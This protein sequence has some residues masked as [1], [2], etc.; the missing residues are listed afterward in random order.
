MN[1]HGSRMEF[2]SRIDSLCS[3]SNGESTTTSGPGE[4]CNVR[5]VGRGRPKAHYGRRGTLYRVGI[6]TWGALQSGSRTGT[7]IALCSVYRRPIL[8]PIVRSAQPGISLARGPPQGLA[9]SEPLSATSRRPKQ[10]SN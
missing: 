1:G 7:I 9:V 10:A 2:Q 3:G 5:V 8:N 6:K 4:T